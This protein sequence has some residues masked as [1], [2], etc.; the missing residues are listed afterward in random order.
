MIIVNYNSYVGICLFLLLLLGFVVKEFNKFYN[1]MVIVMIKD[2][3]IF[4]NNGCRVFIV[5]FDIY[6]YW[7]L[8]VFYVVRW[9]C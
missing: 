9:Y 3:Y 4:W 2:G 7:V 1:F 6:V 5:Y 8:F